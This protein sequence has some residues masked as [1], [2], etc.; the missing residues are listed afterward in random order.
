MNYFSVVIHG[1]R[2]ALL[3]YNRP[4]GAECSLRI[5]TDWHQVDNQRQVAGNKK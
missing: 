4:K 3:Q 2:Q 1:A 5:E